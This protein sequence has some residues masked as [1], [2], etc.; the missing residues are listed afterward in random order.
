[1]IY[2]LLFTAF[3]YGFGLHKMWVDSIPSRDWAERLVMI[4][5]VIG[6]PLIFLLA[7][8]AW[9]IVWMLEGMDWVQEKFDTKR[10]VKLVSIKGV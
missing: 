4:A 3:A 9:S 2:L 7:C 5:L 1:M 10:H 6:W 8:I